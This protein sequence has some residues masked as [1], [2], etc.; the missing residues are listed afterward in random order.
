VLRYTNLVADPGT[1]VQTNIG[2]TPP[3][4]VNNAFY[5]L[6]LEP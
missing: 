4:T 3:L 6:R 5:R 1:L 2:A